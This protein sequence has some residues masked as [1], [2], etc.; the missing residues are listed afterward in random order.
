MALGTIEAQPDAYYF[1]FNGRS[2]K[3]YIT[4]DRRVVQNEDSDLQ[5]TLSFTDPVP[6]NVK[7][8]FLEKVTI[9]DEQGTIY[10]FD[11]AETSV[12]QYDDISSRAEQTYINNDVNWRSY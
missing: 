12:L 11:V 1:S 4:P 8:S 3:F 5:I 7:E 2:G 9:R 10:T 6:S